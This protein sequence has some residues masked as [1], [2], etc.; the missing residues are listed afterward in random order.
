M[1]QWEEIWNWVCE[2]GQGR[3]VMNLH[4]RSTHLD[5]TKCWDSA[6]TLLGSGIIWRHPPWTALPISGWGN[7]ADRQQLVARCLCPVDAD[8]NRLS[9]HFLQLCLP[10]CFSPIKLW[11]LKNQATV[12]FRIS[13]IWAAEACNYYRAGRGALVVS[14][15]SLLFAQS[16]HWNPEGFSEM[17]FNA[18]GVS[19]FRHFFIHSLTCNFP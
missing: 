15:T 5:W 10:H 13:S 12:V 19:C 9:F 18:E 14:L 7:E 11:V 1:E 3:Y 2:E 16:F 8:S 4:S 6:C 17:Q